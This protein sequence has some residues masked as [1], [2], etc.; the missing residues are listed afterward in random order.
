MVVEKKAKAEGR[1]PPGQ[2]LTVRWPALHYGSIPDLD[3]ARWDFKISGLVEQPRCLTWD[4]F[5][6]LPQTEVTSDFHCVTGWSRLDNTWKGVL[7]TD[8]LKLA[9]PSAKPNSPWSSPS[10]TTPPTYRSP[11][12]SI[13]MSC[14][15]WI[16]TASR[17]HRS[18]GV[19]CA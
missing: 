14:S 12:C 15:L 4:D 6:A 19:L 2:S 17:A 16:T 18:T 11:I 8:V 13:P 3:S 7:F 5:R 9:N 1:L 10:K